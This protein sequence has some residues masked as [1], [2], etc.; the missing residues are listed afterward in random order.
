MPVQVAYPGG[1]TKKDTPF[2]FVSRSRR[3]SGLRKTKHSTNSL[4]HRTT[5][6]R[7]DL[8]VLFQA[9]NWAGDSREFSPVC[10]FR[11]RILVEKLKRIRRSVSSLGFFWLYCWTG[12]RNW[13]LSHQVPGRGIRFSPGKHRLERATPPG[14]PGIRD[15]ECQNGRWLGA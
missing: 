8:A 10:L 5:W 1:K 3:P 11:W 9:A 14:T 6:L 15:P 7:S 4:A 13:S 2:G 12:Q